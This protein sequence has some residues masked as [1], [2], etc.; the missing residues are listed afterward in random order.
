MKG[1]YKERGSKKAIKKLFPANTKSSME[2][3]AVMKTEN[4]SIQVTT[5][6]VM[7]ENYFH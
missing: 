5:N 3:S 7:K 1:K 4:V 6:K 2:L